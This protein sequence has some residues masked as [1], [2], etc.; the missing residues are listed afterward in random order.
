M[1]GKHMLAPKSEKERHE[2]EFEGPHEDPSVFSAFD[3]LLQ[4]K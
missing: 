3:S 2:K 1:L 4:S